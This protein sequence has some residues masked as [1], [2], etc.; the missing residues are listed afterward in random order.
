MAWRVFYSYS[1]KDEALRDKLASCLAPLKR[2]NKIVEW[3]D[4]KIMAGALWEADIN[5]HIDTADLVLLL[6]SENFLKSTY[7]FGIELEKAMARLKRG[8]VRVIPI[9]LEKC[10]WDE[11]RFRELQIIPRDNKPVTEAQAW[12]SM[13]EAWEVVAVEIDKVVSESTER[14][15]KPEAAPKEREAYDVSLDLV[16]EQLG[17]YANIYERTRQL[18]RASNERTRR[19]TAIFNEMREL[20]T[21]AYPLLD[22]L[23]NSPAPGERLAAVA[24]L[25]VLAAEK[26]LPF[27]VKVLGAEKPFVGF[28]A[29]L[30]LS[31]AVRSLHPRGYARLWQAIQEAKEAL[32]TAPVSEDRERQIV[33]EAA[34]VELRQRMKV[35]GG[36]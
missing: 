18:M 7:C 23:A 19:M 8:E 27:L 5:T 9:L 3:H 36:V 1:H 30:A 12:A 11:S 33:L 17:A 31:K 24:V 13:D 21:A 2:Q 28:Q 35:L 6:I 20:A 14:L 16:R 32:K 10:K 25:Q 4:R 29:A 34:E 26:H 15:V 22:E